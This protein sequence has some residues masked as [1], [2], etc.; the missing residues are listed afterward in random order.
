MN[1]LEIFIGS[2]NLWW[3]GNKTTILVHIEMIGLFPKGSALLLRI[4]MAVH[5]DEKDLFQH[6]FRMWL[7]QNNII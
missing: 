3:I 1:I 6:G 5:L 2:Y 4:S 7:V